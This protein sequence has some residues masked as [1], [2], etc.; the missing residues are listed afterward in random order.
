MI[1]MVNRNTWLTVNKYFNDTGT[2]NDKLDAM[3][4]GTL[5][6]VGTPWKNI[7]LSPDKKASSE[8]AIKKHNVKLSYDVYET[9]WLK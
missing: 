3:G 6:I 5:Q 7:F 9:R 1:F 4:F 2:I 8:V